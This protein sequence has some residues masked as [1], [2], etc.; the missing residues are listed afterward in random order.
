MNN[1]AQIVGHTTIRTE[2]TWVKTY[3]HKKYDNV[4][5]AHYHII[6][7]YLNKHFE[8]PEIMQ[9]SMQVLCYFYS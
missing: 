4:L 2:K 9:S 3:Y 1:L 5:F 7:Y 8:A 6:E